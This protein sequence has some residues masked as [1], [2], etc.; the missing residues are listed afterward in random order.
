MDDGGDRIADDAQVLSLPPVV[1]PTKVL[2]V[3]LSA[4]EEFGPLVN[5]VC[6][7]ALLFH[8]PTSSHEGQ[9]RNCARL[10]S[11]P[12]WTIPTRPLESA[13]RATMS[14]AR[15][16]VSRS[17]LRV[18]SRAVVLIATLI[19]WPLLAIQNKTMTLRYVFACSLVTCTEAF[20][21][22]YW[23]VGNGIRLSS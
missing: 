4:K 20:F 17:T 8:A 22:F 15:R 5:E 16:L 3:P 10:A 11:F 14:L 12:E 7:C 1:A 6:A 21:I 18:R 9:R 2:I 13:M 19:S 23:C